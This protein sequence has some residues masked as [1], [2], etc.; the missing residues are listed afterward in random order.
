M[1]EV[2]AALDQWLQGIVEAPPEAA[3][4]TELIAHAAGCPRCTGGLLTFIAA[5]GGP[6]PPP[7]SHDCTSIAEQLPSFVDYGG[8]RGLAAAA[9]AFPAVWWAILSCAD[10]AAAH[11]ALQGAS[12][13]PGDGQRL[14]LKISGASLGRLVGAEQRLG[15]AW[16]EPHSELLL[17][18]EEHDEHRLQ[19]FLRRKQAGRLTLIMRSDPPAK[20]IATLMIDHRVFYRQLDSAGAAVFD[21]LVETLFGPS[22]DLI[23][24]LDTL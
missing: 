11:G 16:G 18:E 17:R 13:A 6:W 19:L 2:C 21:D 1:Q 20:G 14:R 4:A 23:L 7:A 10:C 5:R 3:P 8:A 15:V 12:A 22:G 24:T 9:V